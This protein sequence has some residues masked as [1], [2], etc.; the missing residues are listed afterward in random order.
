MIELKSR[1]LYS[2]P[3]NK[4]KILMTHFE[5]IIN[6]LRNESIVFKPLKESEY[7]A[8]IRLVENKDLSIK[9]IG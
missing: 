3:E 2:D 1:V 9:F 4:P 6:E 5:Y 7:E 8:I